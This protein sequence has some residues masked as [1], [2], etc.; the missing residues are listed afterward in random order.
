MNELLGA[1][2]TPRL[3]DYFVENLNREAQKE[4]RNLWLLRKSA[5][6][7]F[8]QGY[9]KVDINSYGVSTILSLIVRGLL[10]NS[11]C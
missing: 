10:M 3:R 9:L 1:F 4:Y 7:A 2:L 5:A 8:A 6:K 11:H